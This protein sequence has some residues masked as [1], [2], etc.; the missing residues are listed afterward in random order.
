VYT[1]AILISALQGGP[2]QDIL[3]VQDLKVVPE[4]E[5]KQV[6]WPSEEP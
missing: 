2:V 4:T 5:T 6:G 1:S 3:E